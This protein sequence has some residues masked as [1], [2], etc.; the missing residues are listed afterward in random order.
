[1]ACLPWRHSLSLPSRAGPDSDRASRLDY[2]YA[3]RGDPQSE[4]KVARGQRAGAALWG[5]EVDGPFSA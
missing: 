3:L 2:F 1:M 5:A 4:R